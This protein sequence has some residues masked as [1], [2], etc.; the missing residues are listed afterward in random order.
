MSNRKRKAVQERKQNYTP[1]LSYGAN[2][3]PIHNINKTDFN[4]EKQPRDKLKRTIT[5]EQNAN[6][7]GLDILEDET[8]AAGRRVGR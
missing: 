7:T 8:T 6:G 5:T 4:C 3:S 1:R 2:D